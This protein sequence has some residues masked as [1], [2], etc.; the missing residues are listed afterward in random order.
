MS[1]KKLSRLSVVSLT[2][3]TL[4]LVTS[5]T[6]WHIVTD[7]P[8]ALK[9]KPNPYSGVLIHNVRL[10]SMVAEAQEVEDGMAVLIRGDRIIEVGATSELSAPPDFL[11][12]D[13]HGQTLMPGLIDAHIHLQD[14]AELAAYLAHGVTGVRNMSGYPFHLRLI[15]RLAAGEL[16]GPEMMTTGP[17]LNSRGPNE[18]I[19]QTTVTTADEARAAV[20][21][22]FNAGYREIKVYSNLSREAF[23][24]ILTEATT[25]GMDVSGHSAEGVRTPG[26]PHDK[27]FDVPWE[28]SLGQ[29]IKTLEHIETI[30]WHSLRD[31][32]DENRM[33]EVAA[34]LAVSGEAVTPTLYAHQR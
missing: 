13:G 7:I 12:I 15:E 17:I 31:A 18:T 5:L 24:A 11:I 32:L 30:V 20:H 25:L 33:R 21:A 1:N 19:L 27:P 28:A 29:G 14:E 26:I 9:P 3:I 23:E 10:I 6:L 34:Q 2:I 16:L 8:N 22:Q 4:A